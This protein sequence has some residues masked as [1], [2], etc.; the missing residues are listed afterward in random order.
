MQTVIKV[1][2]NHRINLIRGLALPVSMTG[3][4]GPRL[5]VP[6]TLRQMYFSSM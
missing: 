1:N 3:G 5:A 2:P 4:H 6:Q